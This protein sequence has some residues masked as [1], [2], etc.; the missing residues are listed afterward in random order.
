MCLVLELSNSDQLFVTLAL[1]M[2]LEMSTSSL[3]FR[4]SE[5]SQHI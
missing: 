3:S 1:I 2:V 5:L 4:S